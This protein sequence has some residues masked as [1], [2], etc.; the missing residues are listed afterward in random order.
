MVWAMDVPG[1]MDKFTMKSEHWNHFHVA[2]D[3]V[4][5]QMRN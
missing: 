5:V 4:T 2:F 1:L 3:P